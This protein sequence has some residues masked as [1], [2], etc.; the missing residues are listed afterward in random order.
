MRFDRLLLASATCALIA[1]AAAAQTTTTTSTTRASTGAM[2]QPVGATQTTTT[3]NTTAMNP[4]A[5][6]AP[7]TGAMAPSATAAFQP[8]TPAAG[9]SIVAVLQASGQFTTLLKAVAATN[10]T[11]VLE[12]PG[13]LTVFAPTDAAFAALPAGQLASLMLPANASQLQQLVLLHVVNTPIRSTELLNHAA[14]NVPTVA[15]GK[16]V[17]LDGSTGT[18]KVDGNAVLQSDVKASNGSIFV[19]G[20]V[21]SPTY[22]A[23]AG[24]E[25][26]DA[27][28]AET[29]SADTKSTTTKSTTTT[30]HRK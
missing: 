26:A 18:L 27:P 19:V 3:S 16:T 5:M 11:S 21:L 15:T 28:A 20:Q 22:V 25:A 7:A 10:L 30:K 2:G 24:S 9:S 17:H 29:K 13:T 4:G 6:T 8:I 1:G 14:T 23:P 12:R